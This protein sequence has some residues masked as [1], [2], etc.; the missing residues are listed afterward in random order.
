MLLYVVS[1]CVCV[2]AGLC[3]AVLTFAPWSNGKLQGVR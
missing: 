3:G 1:E 2:R